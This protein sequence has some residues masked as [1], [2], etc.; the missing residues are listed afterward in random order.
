MLVRGWT[1][2]MLVPV[3]ALSGASTVSLAAA[4]TKGCYSGPP[5]SGS[6]LSG[7]AATSP[8]SAWAVGRYFN[9]NAY[10]TLVEQ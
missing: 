2:F 6:S 9:G 8:T 1:A 3:V 5:T 7:V 10:Q 4:T